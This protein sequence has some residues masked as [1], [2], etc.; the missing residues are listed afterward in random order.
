[1]LE[2]RFC[3]LHG[4]LVFASADL[5]QLEFALLNQTAPALTLLCRS[6]EFHSCSQNS[7]KENAEEDYYG[8]G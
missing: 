3:Y 6:S 5:F 1:M 8:L 4:L 7:N 2:G